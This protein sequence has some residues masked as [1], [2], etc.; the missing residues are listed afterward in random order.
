MDSTHAE[1]S[2]GPAGVAAA[3]VPRRPGRQW[4]SLPPLPVTVAPTAPLVTGPAPVLAP[5]PGSR[6]VY[7]PPIA[8]QAGRVEGLARTVAREPEPSTPVVATPLPPAPEPMTHRPVRAVPATPPAP[9]TEA[10]SAYVGAP[11]E[12]AEPHRAPGWLRYAPAWLTQGEPDP[13]GLPM[14]RPEPTPEP[15]RPVF[16]PTRLSEAPVP[17]PES[18]V[19]PPARVTPTL[20]LER[21]KRR[22][23]LGQSRKLGLGAP[24]KKAGEQDLVPPPEPPRLAA[25]TPAP[26]PAPVPAP[27]AERARTAERPA[28]EE[29]G[30]EPPLPQPPP[31]PPPPPLSH[32][33]SPPPPPPVRPAEAV[34]PEPPAKPV[35]PAAVPLVYKGAEGRRERPAATR[36][37]TTQVP[38]GLAD[39][40][41]GRTGVDV[42]DVPVHRTPEASA[43]ARTLGARAFTRDAQVYLPEE[44]GPLDTPKARGLLAHEL[45]HVVQQRT[46]GP[47][48][49]TTDGAA[50]EAEAV[51]A[52][53]EHGGHAPAP[54]PLR[55]PSLTQVIG[56]A[57][58]TAGVQLAPLAGEPVIS[59][60]TP[61][62]VT[63]AMPPTPPAATLS[64]PVRQ[65]IGA[66]SE[67]TA[68]ASATRV[69]ETWSN[70]DLGGSGFSAGGAL[71]LSLPAS[72]PAEPAPVPTAGQPES[73]A[74][75]EM[76]NQVLQVINLDRTSK[77]EQPLTTLDE[78]TTAQIRQ[79]I[80]EQLAISTNRSM[81]MATALASAGEPAI[82]GPA[83]AA[84]A[85]ET[86]RQQQQPAP[87][88]VPVPAPAPAPDPVREEDS[89]LRDGQIDLEKIDLDDLS[90]RLY[91]RLRSR[92]RMELLIDRERA[93]LLTDFR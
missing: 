81:L 77:G 62:Q 23:T 3:G 86:P 8:T 15:P 74:E 68:A 78:S 39:A 35:Q 4:A 12:P 2:T 49:S 32:K 5:L 89:A 19:E 64:D 55:H 76:A 63:S 82:T 47:A 67:Q 93:G 50:L 90:T 14:S 59:S 25:A 28:E 54:A 56:Q 83:P 43:E 66:I 18:T 88:P 31:Q 17:A 72:A 84:A 57:A 44:A 33:P 65:D 26:T 6:L 34:A 41:R 60:V 13:L 22:A 1:P 29:A 70:P 48:L 75:S 51:A 40:I 61:V 73:A 58:R 80:A 27:P 46:L 45:V 16:P 36:Q 69:L 87:E 24:I 52:E 85:P 7:G 11:R 71:P 37:G 42:A 91:D 21:P 38:A 92:L 79:A 30:E 10:T 20:P 9:L 53:H